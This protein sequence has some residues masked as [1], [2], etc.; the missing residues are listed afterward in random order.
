MR[1]LI[2]LISLVVWLGVMAPSAQ[3]CSCG[4][5]GPPCES[6]GS[7]SAVFVGTVI[8]T[9][10]MDKPKTVD[11]DDVF[12]PRL[13]KFSVEQSYLGVAGT[14]FEILTGYGGGDC[15]YEF[16]IGAR[17]LVYASLHRG[18]LVTTTCS[19]TRPFSQAAEDLAFLGNLSSATPGATIHGQ[20][21]RI[22]NTKSE[23][24]SIASEALI[25]IE[26]GN[27][28]REVRLDNEGRYRASGLP[29]GKFK[30]KLQLPETLATHQP[31]QELDVSDRGC[32]SVDYYI[33]DNGR[34]AG[35]VIDAEGQSISNI[36]ISL[37]DPVADPKQDFRK[38]D[39]TDK[40]G[41][42]SF[43]AIPS[44]RYLLAVN[45]HRFGDPQDPTLA[46]PSVFYPGVVDQVNAEL[47][48]LGI[49]EKRTGVEVRVPLR[50]SASV[51]NGQVVWADGSP[52]ENAMVLL[53]EATG[54]PG[55][56]NAL[57]GDEHGRFTF[58]GYVGQQLILAASS[59][60]PYVPLGTRFEPME[61]SEPVRVTLEKSQ[62]TV[63]IV[64]TKIR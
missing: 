62:E 26:A 16:K 49:G 36:V 30:I 28:R 53:S 24:A 19:R 59:K 20:L 48:Q 9:R 43:S 41:R 37:W 3:A 10:E 50:K 54:Q 40:E 12:Y 58:N 33:T 47:I 2:V 21:L 18:K 14:E 1:Y 23:L 4:G 44:G 51:L 27:V 57:Q 64:I 63:K 38:L 31:E 6:Y 39:R 32:G 29:A 11:R 25:T 13:F 7:A 15:G 56:L 46:Y 34:V 52:V 61:R 22:K 8:G 60:R 17:Y 35:R 5:S 55:N 42:F 45:H